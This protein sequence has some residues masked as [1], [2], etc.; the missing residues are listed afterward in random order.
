MC[1][2]IYII[3]VHGTDTYYANKTYIF[4]AINHYESFDS[5]IYIINMQQQY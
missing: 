2:Y 3:N 1:I 5:T 4:D